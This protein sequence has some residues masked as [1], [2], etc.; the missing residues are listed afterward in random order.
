[1]RRFLSLFEVKHVGKHFLKG[2]KKKKRDNIKSNT[3]TKKGNKIRAFNLPD[4]A[5][6]LTEF[7]SSR[8]FTYVYSSK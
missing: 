6:V 2:K 4:I 5:R 8:S 1:M 3:Q 7:P